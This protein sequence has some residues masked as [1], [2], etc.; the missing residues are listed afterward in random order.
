[1]RKRSN[2]SILQLGIVLA[3][4]TVMIGCQSSGGQS[5]SKQDSIA[6]QENN[7]GFESIFDGKT[8]NGW[9]GDTA[10]WHVENGSIVGQETTETAPLLKANTFLIWQGGEPSDF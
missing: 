8:L 10:Y 3:T 5:E 7:D 4:V 9:D 2:H 6:Q 1:M